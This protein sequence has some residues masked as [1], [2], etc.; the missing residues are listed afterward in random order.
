MANSNK[1]LLNENLAKKV[2]E[3]ASDINVVKLNLEPNI[4]NFQKDE[5]ATNTYKPEFLSNYQTCKKLSAVNFD[6]SKYEKIFK[7]NFTDDIVNENLQRIQ[8]DNPKNLLLAKLYISQVNQAIKNNQNIADDIDSNLLNELN[9]LKDS[10]DLDNYIKDATNRK[11][12]AEAYYKLVQNNKDFQKFMAER[13]H[14]ILKR[15]KNLD[16][17]DEQQVNS[18]LQNALGVSGNILSV[19]DSHLLYSDEG[20]IGAILFEATLLF[21]VTTPAKLLFNKDLDLGASTRQLGRLE[22]NVLGSQMAQKQSLFPT[23]G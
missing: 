19:M 2:E 22:E 14:R 16:Q 12:I 11:K 8:K 4:N 18:I 7:N 1:T 23:P 13:M 17:Y 3:L 10:N 20:R 15:L 9:K 21:L 5:Y 6:F